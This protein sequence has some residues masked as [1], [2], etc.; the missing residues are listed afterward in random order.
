MFDDEH[1]TCRLSEQMLPSTKSESTS[2]VYPYSQ[3]SLIFGLHLD[4]SEMKNKPGSYEARLV[5]V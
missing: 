4:Y 3:A 5:Q 2:Q 1:Q